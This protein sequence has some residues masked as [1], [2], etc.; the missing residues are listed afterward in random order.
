MRKRAV[1]TIAVLTGVLSGLLTRPA[2]GD[3]PA[4]GELPTP[5]HVVVAVFENH[6]AA[7]ILGSGEAPYFDELAA[8]GAR[9]TAS[10]GITHPSQPNYLA[11]F[12]GGI[13]GVTGDEC[14]RAGFSNGPNLASELI[15]KGKTWASYNEGLPGQG[16]TSCT[17]GRYARKHN[18]WFAFSN[19]P[20]DTARTLDQFPSDYSRLPDVSFVVP[21]LCNSMHDCSVSTGDAWLK[22]TLGAY[23]TWAKTHNSLLVVTFDED[24][25][26]ADN[27]IPTVLYGQPV[28]AGSTTGTSYTH[29]NLLRTLEDMSGTDHAGA[30]ADASAVTGIWNAPGEPPPPPPSTAPVTTPGS[31]GT[32]VAPP[33][34]TSAPTDLPAPGGAIQSGT[35]TPVPGT[36]TP[37]PSGAPTEPGL[38]ETGASPLIGWLTG[39][40]VL[41]LTAG[42]LLSRKRMRS[43]R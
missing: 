21:D 15:A 4:P 9:L 16:S 34:S 29:Y 7:Q 18:P 33:P 27:Q 28:R 43:R 37:P 20:T 38:P 41:L 5:D 19:V 6:S 22:K 1:L 12:S 13:Q 26:N 3:P 8:G 23:A 25:R 31:S 30:A 14:Y 35:S 36:Q 42:I 10:Y 39:A 11:L 2:N 32:P 24:N 40:A 17:E